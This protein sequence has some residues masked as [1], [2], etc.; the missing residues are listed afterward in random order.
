MLLSI[1]VTVYQLEK[2]VSKT[3]DS[4]TR[5][6]INEMEIIIVNDGSKDNSEKVIH[7]YIQQHPL[8]RILL[9][10][11]ENAGVS[12]ARNFGALKASGDYLLYLDGDDIL[13][14]GSLD[15]IVSS[16]IADKPDILY[17]PYD[18]VIESG[19][20][21]AKYPFQSSKSVQSGLSALEDLLIN[22]SFYLVIG[23]AAYKSRM[24]EDNELEFS[25]GCVAGEDMEFTF[26]AISVAQ[27]VIYC[28]DAL[29][30]YLQRE[31]STIHRYNIRRFDSIAALNRASIF[32]FSRPEQNISK[33]AYL[34]SGKETLI[35]Y[36]GTYRMSLEQMM[37]EN[38]LS[39]GPA[40]KLLDEDLDENYPRLRN[41][42]KK[43]LSI[44][45][46]FMPIN[47]F[48]IFIL[49]P[50]L[51]MYLAKYRLKLQRYISKLR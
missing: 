8:H 13:T 33:L 50:V 24:L 51:Y 48:G 28:A 3:L 14:C 43:E 44:Q 4:L 7:T 32:I 25:L 31:S 30:Q 36:I 42:V 16:L 2:Y 46:K 35:N 12:A 5:K 17:W 18:V 10:T 11:T 6:I 19:E 21:I 22:K 27:S 39:S 9:Y 29:L 1:I 34:V 41:Q 47:K 49:S 23:N 37:E 45:N 15:K 20:C 40:M 38:K 26:K